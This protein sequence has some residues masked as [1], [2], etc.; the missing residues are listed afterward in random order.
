MWGAPLP[1]VLLRAPHAQERDLRGVTDM[2]A[3]SLNVTFKQHGTLR[4]RG[5]DQ[6]LWRALPQ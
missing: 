3:A 4:F 2:S 5:F 1:D 6:A